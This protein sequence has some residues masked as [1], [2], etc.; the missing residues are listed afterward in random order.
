MTQKPADKD[1]EELNKMA[2]E[3]TRK[4]WNLAAKYSHHPE[5]G[6]MP[7][8]AMINASMIMHQTVA[9]MSLQLV[10]NLA[11]YNEHVADQLAQAAIRSQPS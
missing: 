6:L 10:T 9:R 8:S 1:V 4:I 3:L 5:G 11:K 2:D 7:F